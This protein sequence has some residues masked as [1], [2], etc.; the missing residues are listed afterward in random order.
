M[1]YTEVFFNL[2]IDIFLSGSLV[3]QIHI[4]QDE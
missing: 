4:F 3:T 1:I 2:K